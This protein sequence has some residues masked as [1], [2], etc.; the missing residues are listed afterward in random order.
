[1]VLTDLANACCWASL[2]LC[3][4][5]PTRVEANQDLI[6]LPSYPEY[7]NCSCA[8]KLKL[9]PTFSF[10]CKSYN[11]A[12]FQICFSFCTLYI[13]SANYSRVFR[14]SGRCRGG[15]LANHQRLPERSRK[16]STL[17][18]CHFAE[19]AK[20]LPPSGSKGKGSHEFLFSLLFLDVLSCR[21]F[22]ESLWQT[23]HWQARSCWATSWL[24]QIK[25]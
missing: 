20:Q 25:S 2:P 9:K 12:L 19:N 23:L 16:Y 22:P 17:I 24:T 15:I 21:H 11:H 1:M 3:C 6:I 14:S 18:K 8:Q 13:P 4:R 10:T 7:R 5:H